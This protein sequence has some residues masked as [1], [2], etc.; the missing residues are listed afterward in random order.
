MQKWIRHSVLRQYMILLALFVAVALLGPNPM[1]FAQGT[2]NSEGTTDLPAD[3]TSTATTTADS[4]VGGSA[5]HFSGSVGTAGDADWIKVALSAD[6]MYRFALK[7]ESSDNGTLRTPIVALYTGAGKYIQ[8]AYD[9]LSGRGRDARLHYYVE[10]AGDYWVSASGFED[11]TGTY[12]LRV[13]AVEDDTEPDNISTPGRISV[14]GTASAEIDY[15]GDSDWFKTS[16]ELSAQTTYNLTLSTSNAAL[17]PRLTFHES[18]GDR[19]NV[20]YDAGN[21]Y[22]YTFTPSSAGTYFFAVRAG[23][24]AGV[25]RYTLAFA[26]GGL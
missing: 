12:K 14:G 2:G 9:L 22:G 3:N 8:G 24:T 17:L 5:T 19:I 25:G 18:D 6:Q 23:S 15:R 16:A 10:T 21:Y 13:A 7:G 1:A 4:A 26:I 11:E 20:L